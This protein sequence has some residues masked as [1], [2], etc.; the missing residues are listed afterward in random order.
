MTHEEQVKNSGIRYAV[1]NPGPEAIKWCRDSFGK[2]ALIGRWMALRYTIQF[3]YKS[4]R[5]W[6][7]LR[8]G[9]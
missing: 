6:F 5:D 4:D 9:L 2:P 1:N 7:V 8:W 3:R